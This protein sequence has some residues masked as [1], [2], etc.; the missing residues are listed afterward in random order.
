MGTKTIL[1]E[2]YTSTDWADEYQAWYSRTFRDIPRKALRLHFLSGLKSRRKVGKKDLFSLDEV[3]ATEPFE[4][5][6]F[7]VVRPFEPMTVAETVLSFPGG[8]GL[9]RLYCHTDFSV[10]IMA[11]ELT[12]RGMPFM[13]QEGSVSVCAEADLWMIARYKHAE[14]EA[15]RF[16]PSE[17][18]EV[19]TQALKYNPT[20]E[21]LTGEQMYSALLEME[22]NPEY[23][24]PVSADHAL[25]ILDS[26]VASKIPVVVAVGE[27]EPDHVVT[28]V[29][30]G[31][32][33]EAQ[34]WAG[35]E[36]VAAYVNR[37]LVHDD[38]TGPYQFLKI[39]RKAPTDEF[40]ERL[41]IGDDG[42]F[43]C[44][45]PL[46]PRVHL[47]QR[48]VQETAREWLD[49][50]LTRVLTK[51]GWSK[52]ALKNLRSRVRLV[53][54]IEFKARLRERLA[55]GGAAPLPHDIV[56]RYWAMDMPRY[57]WLIDLL[58][59]G[60]KPED[61]GLGEMVFDSTAHF[62]DSENSMLSIR[63]EGKFLYRENGQNEQT[64]VRDPRGWGFV[65]YPEAHPPEEGL[66]VADAGAAAAAAPRSL[67]RE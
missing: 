26:Y 6:G 22:F 58:A 62:R 60:Q 19:A 54:S 43:W 31:Y 14:G 47:R 59:S 57:V 32:G 67:A 65:K 66:H 8:E 23:L 56:A 15:R 55:N 7:S 2:P 39:D 24:W 11:A 38:A 52:E 46:P 48:D 3:R 1:V 20:R 37:V 28:V 10:H 25:G 12:V 64:T 49:G 9:P 4:Y 18:E 63:L 40:P 29:G 36:T 42:I 33:T 34:P 30:H 35:D 16:R 13:Q 53:R 50:S 21:G 27:E 41:A 51:K 61:L 45:I 44:L 17:M 5:L